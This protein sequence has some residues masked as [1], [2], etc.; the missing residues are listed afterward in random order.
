MVN[1]QA[2]AVTSTFRTVFGLMLLT[3]GFFA[4]LA[5]LLG[6]LG[7]FWWAFD[8]LANFRAQ[9]ALVLLLIAAL[10]GLVLSRGAGV[11]FFAIGLVNV[12]L[13]LPLYLGSPAD[14]DGTDELS[15]ASVNVSAGNEDRSRLLAWVEEVGPDLVFLLEST[16]EWEEAI[17][18]A[19]AEF[20]YS[21]VAGVPD[22]RRFGI[23]VIT[24]TPVAEVEVLRLGEL[25]DPVVRLETTLDGRPVVVYVVHPRPATSQGGSEAR[26][27]LLSEVAAAAADEVDAV[28]VMGDL[29]ATPWSHAFRSLARE[30]DL[31][32]SLVGFGLQPTWPDLPLGLTI[33][34]DHML[35]SEDLTTKERSIG[36][37]LGSDHKPLLVTIGRTSA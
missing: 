2:S 11:V 6:F 13:V 24:R 29:N 4:T 17:A 28:V 18:R 23:T 3:V 34:I 35:H 9:Y 19:P 32:N 33:P 20:G 7:S 25:R 1:R 16:E 37:S 5:T 27:S 22:N 8:A 26:D 10:Y 30:A 15:M 21:I 14:A 36:P 12:W 31:V